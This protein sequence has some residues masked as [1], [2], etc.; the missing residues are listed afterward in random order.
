VPFLRRAENTKGQVVASITEGGVAPASRPAKGPLIYR[1]S[2][3][4]RVTHWVWVICLFFLLSSGLGIFNAHPT[5]YVGQQSSFPDLQSNGQGFGAAWLDIGAVNTPNGPRGQTTLLGHPIDTTG[6]LG[7]SG[8]ASN[9][10]FLAFPSWATIPSYYDLATA[11]V[12]H[13]FFAWIL[14]A[15]LAVWLVASILNRHIAGIPPTPRDLRHL[16]RDIL[17]HLR[18]RFEHGRQYNVLQK[19]AYSV[20]FIFLFPLIILTGLTMSPGMDSAWPWL[21]ELFGGRQ[22]ARSI[23]FLTMTALVLFFIVHIIMVV[24]A[25][26]INELRQMITGR[27]RASP[28]VPF[29]A[30]KKDKP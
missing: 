12:V 30:T 29:D 19:I 3:F 25:N 8:D 23:H 7:M 22:T 6:V 11:R 21:L 2:I 5:L 13:F 27:Y 18:L 28:N 9:P 17:D 1:Q 14:V 15:T 20:V 24:L 4:T 16:P 26:P 10:T